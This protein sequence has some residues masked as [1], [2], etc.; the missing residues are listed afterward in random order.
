MT[1]LDRFWQ[2]HRY[3]LLVTLTGSIF[4]PLYHPQTVLTRFCYDPR[5]ETPCPLPCPACAIEC[6]KED[7]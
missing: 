6:N 3:A 7:A 4:L 1:A 5:H 2:A